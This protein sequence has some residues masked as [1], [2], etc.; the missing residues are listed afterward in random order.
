M[1]NKIVSQKDIARAAGVSVMTVSRA[2]RNQPDI[3]ETMRAQI[4]ELAKRMGYQP[5]PLLSALMTYRRRKLPLPTDLCL[6]YVTN[7]SSP[8]EWKNNPLY[9]EFFHGAAAA[10]KN[11]GYHLE[12]FSLRESGMTGR[13]LSQI[14]YA[15]G[16]NGLVIAPLPVAQGHLRLDWARFSCVAIGLSLAYPNL[17]RVSPHQFRSMRLVMRQLRHRGYLRIGMAVPIAW[18][19]RVNRQWVGSFLAEQ[20]LQPQSEQ[21]P[22]LLSPAKSL[23]REEFLAWYQEHKPDVIISNQV[24]PLDW[25]K[26]LGMKTPA[27]F[28]FVHLESTE[29]GTLISG[30]YQN[31][32]VIGQ[33]ALDVLIGLLNQNRKGIPEIPTMTLVDSSWVE[34][35]TLRSAGRP[36]QPE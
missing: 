16:I 26:A 35:T 1:T 14:L 2:L 22:L 32:Q 20:I 25:L 23:V 10:A 36:L 18:N 29:P 15:R 28:G 4:L 11:C 8:E 6:G 34:G 9:Q 5:N 17:H 24:E 27:D 21:V 30:I 19:E 33:T 3:S 31:G 13:R 12:E 7:F